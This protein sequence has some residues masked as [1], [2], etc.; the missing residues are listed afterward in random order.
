MN[1]EEA[2]TALNEAVLAEAE[3]SARAALSEINQQSEQAKSE[4]AKT[5]SLLTR[6]AKEL[7]EAEARL[8][9]AREQQAEMVGSID[10]LKADAA[11]LVKQL[12]VA[13]GG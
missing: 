9:Q 2:L 10:M 3:K 1:K 6:S 8:A 12:R 5:R 4:L 7:Q 13:Q 11:V